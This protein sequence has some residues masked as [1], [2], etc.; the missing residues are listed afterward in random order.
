QWNDNL[1]YVRGRHTMKFGTEVQRRQYNVFQATSPRGAISYGSVYTTNP[2]SPAGT[3]NG[4]ADL[5]LGVPQSGNIQ[6]IAG[7]RGLRRTEWALYLQDTFKVSSRLTLNYGL[8]YD[9]LFGWPWTEV[10]N[11]QAQFLPE[12]GQ[13]YQVGTSQVPQASGTNTDHLNLSP[14]VGLAYSL[15]PKTVIRA[16]YGVFY[17]AMPLSIDRSL[18]S[19]P[20]FVGIIN[21]ANNQFDYANSWRASQGFPRPSVFPTL[22][23]NLNAVAVN[24]TTPYVQQWNLNVERQIPG[25]ILLTVAYVGSKGTHLLY[26]PNI[27]LPYP[28]PGAVASRRPYPDY[29]N[30]TYF[31]PSAGSNYHGLQLSAEKR[32]ARGLSFL[33]SYGWAHA[34]DDVSSLFGS[35]Q[36]PRNRVSDRG[37]SD[38][39][40]RQRF[41]FSYNW[42]LPLGRGRK[43]LTGAGRAADLLLGG[44]QMNGIASFYTGFP[45]TPTSSTNT[46]NAPGSSQR[47]AYIGGCDPVLPDS[48]WTLGRYFNT[49]CFTTPPAFTFGSSGRNI[50]RGPGTKQ[51]DFS[52]F[53]NFRWSASEARYVQLRGEFFNIFNT[54]QFNNPNSSI[55]SASAGSIS[56]AGSV[57][58]FSRTQRQVQLALKIF[59]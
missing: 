22:G 42:D 47:A 45:F 26:F 48:Q 30:I 27:N 38:Y 37:N 56:S 34:I 53:K 58:T 31:T 20:P 51:L 52:L 4:V 13:V 18:A 12:T 28:G 19:N 40:L 35:V 59:F 14:R 33:A 43:F 15:T 50:L 21:Y 54:P 32:A 3:G 46:L 24:A 23:A 39:D 7:T 29:G 36:D 2:L 49:A 9:V 16:G 55:G 44:W 41:V 1:S 5:L 10:A 17:D 11:R 6:S 57:L 8:R 25:Q